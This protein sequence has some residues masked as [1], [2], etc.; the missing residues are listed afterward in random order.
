MTD[1]DVIVPVL[2]R[3]ASAGPFMRSLRGSV[4]TSR[5]TVTAVCSARDRRTERMWVRHGA[6][7]MTVDDPGTFAR[8]AN[9][10]YRATSSPWLLL[11]GDDV[12][13]HDGW[14][15]AA[16]GAAEGGAVVS[17][18]DHE[19]GDGESCV[20]PLVRRAY[21][22]LQGASWDGPGVACH[23]GYRHNFV[24]VEMARL[25]RDRGLFRPAPGAVIE[26]LHHLWG[27]AT[28]DDTYRIGADSFAADRDLYL[29]RAARYGPTDAG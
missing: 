17:T 13:F 19:G 3:P 9:A 6:D 11:V 29:A 27:T 22:D 25:A 15:D 7:T 21:I 16:L 10:A 28:L 26:H 12:R 8:K 23:E 18:A 4:D 5:V 24:D 1:V 20:H 2:G 14:L